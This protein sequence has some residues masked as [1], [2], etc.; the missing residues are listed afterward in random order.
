MKALAWSIAIIFAA[1]FIAGYFTLGGAI[2][3][4]LWNYA[5]PSLFNVGTIGIKK[6]I[7]LLILSNIL[8]K[9]RINVKMADKLKERINKFK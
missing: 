2:V 1:I 5:M 8:I 3:A 4:T 7:A 6:A 9:P